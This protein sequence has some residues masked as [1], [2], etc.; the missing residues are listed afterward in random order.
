MGDQ[1]T[2]VRYE[3]YA[4]RQF[5]RQQAKQRSELDNRIHCDGRGVL[6]GVAHGVTDNGGVVQWSAFLL[7]LNFDDLL[8]VVP[9]AAGIGHE[10]CLVQAEDRDG[11][12]VANEE[13][14]LHERER[15]CAEE[16]GQKDVEHAFLRVLRADFYDLLAVTDG[17]FLHALEPDIRLDE[18]DGA[19]GS[20]SNGLS[21]GAGEPV[22]HRAS[23]DKPQEEGRVQQR[24]RLSVGGETVGQCHDDGKHHGGRAY[25]GSADENRLGGCLKSIAGA[26]VGFKQVLGAPEVDVEVVLLAHFFLDPRNLLDERKLVDRLRVVRHRTVGIDGNSYRPH[27]QESER[28]QSKGKDGRGDHEVLKP[29]GAEVVCR[30]HQR[31]HRASQPV[32]GEVTSD[33]T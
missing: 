9:R 25:Y 1:G 10:N 28:H 3:A 27:S 20:G 23:G 24:K 18:F 12:Q 17:G 8:G 16:H 6:E 21:G 5:H 11:D 32:G 14:R 30:R 15:Q 33:E 13:K 26:V 31:N 29:H 22:N 4:Y 7:Q 2:I 19:V